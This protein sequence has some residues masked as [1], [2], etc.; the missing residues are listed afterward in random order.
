MI[1][2]I[3]SAPWIS[4][5][6]LWF[7]HLGWCVNYL[8]VLKWLERIPRNHCSQSKNQQ[9]N[10]KY[11]KN[12]KSSKPRNVYFFFS[13][14]KWVGFLTS[15]SVDLSS[16]LK[17]KINLTLLVAVIISWE[18]RVLQCTILTHCGV[19]DFMKIHDL[20]TPVLL[21]YGQGDRRW[22]HKPKRDMM[23]SDTFQSLKCSLPASY[24]KHRIGQHFLLP[25]TPLGWPLGLGQVIP[26]P[27]QSCP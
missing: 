21:A 10:K 9:T 17:T 27:I 7:V 14:S 15:I 20:G 3:I 2:W 6:L 8:A 18:N 22:L 5:K 13:C 26:F 1:K 23:P 25:Y 24:S 12:F 19:I 16:C 11:F 4:L